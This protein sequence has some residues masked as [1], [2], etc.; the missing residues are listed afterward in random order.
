MGVKVTFLTA[1]CA[2][3]RIPKTAVFPQGLSFSGFSNAF[4]DG[5]TAG[6]ISETFMAEMMKKCG[7][8]AVAKHITSSA[9]KGQT[10]DPRGLHHPCSMGGPS[11]KC[12][13]RS[14]IDDPSWSI[15]LPGLPRLTGRDLPSFLSSSNPYD[16]AL[17]LFKQHFDTRDEE[18][19]LRILV[20]S[21]DALE[22]EALRA[23]EKLDLVAVDHLSH[24]RSWT[25][26][27]H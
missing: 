13:S 19:K 21:F 5:W 18:T 2:L 9:E 25:G 20:N 11:C 1:L 26:R 15:H 14:K 24:R 10:C 27:I 6:Y 8:E 3:N 17:P 12:P 22:P 7:S 4:V 16:F 23:I